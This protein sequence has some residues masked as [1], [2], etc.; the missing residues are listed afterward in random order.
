MFEILQ[1]NPVSKQQHKPLR[2]DLSGQ[3]F[4]VQK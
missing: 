2:M 4:N 3:V 1:L